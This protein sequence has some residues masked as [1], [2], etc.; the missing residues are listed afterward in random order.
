MPP[1]LCPQPWSSRFSVATLLS[2][3]D[4]PQCEEYET[5][6]LNI[7]EDLVDQLNAYVV[8]CVNSMLSKLY[9]PNKEPSIVFFRHGVPLLYDASAIPIR[10]RVKRGVPHGLGIPD[11]ACQCFVQCSASLN[12]C[13]GLVSRCGLCLQ[14]VV[15]VLPTSAL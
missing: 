13:L 8:A 11:S 6:L 12:R 7:R 3:K 10:H 14:L 4:C 2:K 1:L 15:L 5:A 9:N